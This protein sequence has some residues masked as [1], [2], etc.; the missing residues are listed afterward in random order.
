ML[1]S[2]PAA[3]RYNGQLSASCLVQMIASPVLE[4]GNNLLADPHSRHRAG[5][6]SKDS[7]A[8]KNLHIFLLTVPCC[9]TAWPSSGHSL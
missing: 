4:R 3:D 2:R 5:A 6:N 8:A 7:Q 9:P 1:H